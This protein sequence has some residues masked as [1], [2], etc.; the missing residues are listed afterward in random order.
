MQKINTAEFS[1]I[2]EAVR[3]S[4]GKTIKIYIYEHGKHRFTGQITCNNL[5]SLLNGSSLKADIQKYRNTSQGENS[6]TTNQY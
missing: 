4:S 6:D 2:G 3:S 5:R 1:V